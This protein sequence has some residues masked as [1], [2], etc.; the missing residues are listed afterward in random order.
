M[1]KRALDSHCHG[2]EQPERTAVT[3]CAWARSQSRR[4]LHTHAGLVQLIERMVLSFPWGVLAID[5]RFDG[6]VIRTALH[7]LAERVGWAQPGSHHM[8]CWNLSSARAV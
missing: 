3:W 7:V 1:Q 8:R 2:L 6:S 4:S 5:C